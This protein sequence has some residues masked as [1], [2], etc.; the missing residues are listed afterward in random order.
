MKKTISLSLAALFCAASPLLAEEISK[1]PESEQVKE[2]NFTLS[3]DFIQ[4]VRSQY[5]NGDYQKFLQQMEKD[6][7]RAKKD[8]ALE[9]LIAMRKEDAAIASSHSATS[10]HWHQVAQS[11]T[12]ERNKELLKLIDSQDT[13]ALAQKIRSVTQ[14]L[15]PAVEETLAYFS[16]LKSL[17][18]GEGRNADENFLIENDLELEY[19]QIH[20]DSISSLDRW[21][22]DNQE[23][24]LALRLEAADKILAASQHFED[25]DLKAKVE[26][27]SQFMDTYY[28]RQIDLKDLHKLATGVLAP[29]NDL[30]KKAAAILSAYEG[31]FS[32]LTKEILEQTQSE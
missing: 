26:T 31:K 7:Q 16:H 29:T 22:P 6:Y 19:K 32:N 24:R 10:D 21:L 15:D 27:L 28:S 4:L 18:P 8:D 13:S 11:W 17:V 25:K 1:A 3:G 30:E 20:F 14:A 23:K 9:G 5:L 12:Q 2:T